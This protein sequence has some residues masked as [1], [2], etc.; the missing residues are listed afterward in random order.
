MKKTYTVIAVSLL[1]VGI[2]LFIWHPLGK[3]EPAPIF[4]DQA[5]PLAL[6]LPP[7]NEF[8]DMVFPEAQNGD[9]CVSS[10]SA[11][12]PADIPQPQ[13]QQLSVAPVVTS[14]PVSYVY[15]FTGIPVRPT[16]QTTI[17]YTNGLTPVP[18]VPVTQ[19]YVAPVFVPQIVPSRVGTPRLVYSNGVV[20]K[21]KVYFP[22]QPVRNTV[23]FIGQ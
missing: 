10:A 16:Q 19:T 12:L 21:P 8:M 11:I 14:S 4:Q 13:E 18:L 20:V 17:F 2:V 1:V 15:F 23:R 5:A 6:L 22:N 9:V 7:E 3:Q